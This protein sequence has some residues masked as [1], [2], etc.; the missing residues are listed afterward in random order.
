MAGVPQQADPASSARIISVGGGDSASAAAAV[1]DAAV[2]GPT[3]A[4]L[5]SIIACIQVWTS[6]NMRGRGLAF[7]SRKVAVVIFS[8]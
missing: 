3:A 5:A 2:A 6:Q 4:E 8:H 7:S 1:V